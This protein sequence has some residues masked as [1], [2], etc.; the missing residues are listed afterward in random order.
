MRVRVRRG[1]SAP[2]RHRGLVE[3]RS[4]SS[5]RGSLRLPPERVSRPEPASATTRG[6]TGIRRRGGRVI[7]ESRPS[8]GAGTLASSFVRRESGSLP[9]SMTSSRAAAVQVR[10]CRVFAV[11]FRRRRL[12]LWHLRVAH[13]RVPFVTFPFVRGTNAGRHQVVEARQAPV[14][15]AYARCPNPCLHLVSVHGANL[16]TCGDG[17]IWF[18][19]CGFD[20]QAVPVISRRLP[21]VRGTNAG[22]SRAAI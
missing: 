22:R 20:A 14:I 18:L 12:S 8:T 3:G 6:A 19:T 13:L 16:A 10:A 21:V 2:E 1:A 4:T 9:A 11:F 17:R 5:C 15:W 7:S